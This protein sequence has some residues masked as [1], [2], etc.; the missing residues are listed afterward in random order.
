MQAECEQ[1]YCQAPSAV[2]DVGG[3]KTPIG[4]PTS[5]QEDSIVGSSALMASGQG[6][7][8][9]D[10]LYIDGGPEHD[11]ERPLE[12]AARGEDT[13][14]LPKAMNINKAHYEKQVSSNIT[15]NGPSASIR[16]HMNIPREDQM[17]S[18][19]DEHA[20][21]V[22][23]D[24]H[25]TA[26]GALTHPLQPEIDGPSAFQSREYLDVNV[27]KPVDVSIR[28]SAKT[29]RP[30][31]SE[32]SN[33]LESL[34][35]SNST[36]DFRTNFSSTDSPIPPSSHVPANTHSIAE[37]DSTWKNSATQTVVGPTIFKATSARPTSVPNFKSKSSSRGRRE[38]PSYPNYPDQ[39]FAALQSQYYPSTHQPQALR[40][41]SSQSSHYTSYSS[42]SSIQP[43]ELPTMQSGAKTVG[44]TPAQSPGLFSPLIPRS[45]PISQDSDESTHRTPALHPAHALHLQTPIETHKLLKDIDPISGR[46]TINDYELFEKLGSG[47]HG[48]VKL[49]RNLTTQQKVAVKIVR[50][51]SKK[52][53]LGRS[54]DPSDMIKKEVAILKK[55]R[56]PHVVSLLEVIDDDEYGKVYLVLEFVEKG[57]IVWR[58][59]TDKDVASFEMN[60]VRREKAGLMDEAFELAEVDRFNRG[61]PARRAGKIDSIQRK[62]NKSKVQSERTLVAPHWSLEHGDGSEEDSS[63]QSEAGRNGETQETPVASSR[64]IASSEHLGVSP[65]E[66]TPKQLDTPKPTPL[67]DMTLETVTPESLAQRKSTQSMSNLTLE[68]FPVELEGTMYGPYMNDDPY[69]NE[70]LRRRLQQ[71]IDDETQWTEEE[72][73]YKHVPCLTLNQVQDAFRDTVLGLEYLHFQGIIHRDIKPA[74]LLW[75]ADFRVKIS[76]FGVSY[77]GKPI[78]NDD[79]IDEELPEADASDITEEVELAKTVGT[80]AFY[81]P[82]LCDPDLFDIESTPHRPRI[83]GQIDVWA[84]GV[85]LY[86]MVFGRLPFLDSNEMAMYEK[87][88]REEVFIPQVR[89][90]GVERSDKPTI[91]SEKRMDDIIEY[92]P[93]DEELCDLLKRLLHKDP[94][95]RINLKDVKHH[96]WVLRGIS[97]Q[98]AWVD[99]TDPSLQSEGKKIEVSSEDVAGAVVA[100]TLVDRLKSGLKRLSSVVRGRDNRKRTDSSV[101]TPDSPSSAPPSKA[102][103]SS[104]EARRTSLRGDEQIFNALRASREGGSDHPLSQSVS[105]SPETMTSS[106]YFDAGGQS[107]V[108]SSTSSPHISR[109]NLPERTLS[110][111]ES[112]RTVRA[113]VPA[114]RETTVPNEESFPSLTTAIDTSSSSSLGGIFHGAGR[115]FVNNMRSRERGRGRDSPSQSSRSSSADTNASN[116]DDSHASPSLAISSAIAAGHVDQ[117]PVLREE[118][119]PADLY[120]T[121]PT[122]SPAQPHIALES[123]NEAFQQAQE[124]NFRRQIVEASHSG[125][126]HPE[127]SPDTPEAPCPPS[128]D[129]V[130]FY[131]QQRQATSVGISSSSEQMASGI[132]ES[133]S[134]PSVPSVVSGASSFSAA[135]DAEALSRSAK[136]VSPSAL[137]PR[138]VSDT[139]EVQQAGTSRDFV[140]RRGKALKVSAPDDDEAGY[141]GEGELDSDSDDDMLMMGPKK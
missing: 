117:P 62:K 84:L 33:L 94:A 20:S 7:A 41:R 28:E 119:S 76:D 110:N 19:R 48:T 54:G 2:D 116:I 17:G 5:E 45:K 77:L 46:K 132:S 123:P 26:H 63:R 30:T 39:S 89:L 134:H 51:F 6:Q 86:C 114:I 56:H 60:R 124:H 141:N 31:E 139:S 103:G 92:E 91:P 65:Q 100:V 35:G 21:Y 34:P 3:T 9:K 96:P 140:E 99:E 70:S 79:T 42:D 58:K 75:T 82:E 29:G 67:D 138:N 88:A 128:P 130:T 131:E 106:S 109:P 25:E 11:E 129:D 107:A 81:A 85:T 22:H 32:E 87:I 95:K 120:Q 1:V 61:A 80:P 52:L 24:L 98:S 83:T 43:R 97:N 38:G 125:L 136:Q 111:A 101:K 69:S 104:Q 36:A 59:Q 78:R 102:S 64:L 57:E 74:N 135:V 122:L 4:T 8:A 115:R 49:G 66:A 27:L 12:R 50:R 72:E 15:G 108:A 105:A 118:P 90:K 18:T 93:I 113:T 37:H 112:A 73:E 40:T 23:A 55:A 14:S 71:F 68:D 127:V 133:F 47:Q 10:T 16:H 13:I 137:V 53:R 121:A 44:N 126:A